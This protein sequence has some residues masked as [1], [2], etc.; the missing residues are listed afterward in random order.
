MYIF[1]FS[2]TLNGLIGSTA[3][4]PKVMHILTT[5]TPTTLYEGCLIQ[6]FFI[7]LYGVCNYSILTVMAYD[8]FVS[9]FHPLHY[10]TIMNP[11]K[12]KQ[13]L[14]VAHFVPALLILGQTGLTS[15]L[16]LCKY[17]IHKLFC[18]NLGVSSL[19]YGSKVQSHLTNLYGVCAIT[20]LVALPV[21]LILLSY[22]KIILLI[23]KASGNARKKAFE[24]CSPH[25]IVFINFSLAT[26]FSVIY[27]RINR[28]LPTEAIIFVSINYILVPPTVTPN[29]IWHK[30]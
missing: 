3:V 23:L 22:V 9:I 27:N 17:T 5:N 14:I 4:W 10:H 30:N 28:F 13:L 20:V 26:P 6:S 29:Y 12:V 11:P 2:L 8:R 16:T 18:D 19:S 15:Q 7:L 25:I 21:L 1:L 24:T